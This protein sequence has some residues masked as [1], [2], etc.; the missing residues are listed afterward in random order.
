MSVIL[1]FAEQRNNTFRK[2]AFEVAGT[3]ARLAGDMGGQAVALVAGADVEGMGPELGKYGVSTVK[4]LSDASF[5]DYT[6]ESYATAV[7]EAAKTLDAKVILFPASSMGKDLAPRVAALLGC[8][9]ASDC[10]ELKVEDGNLSAKRPLYGG[11]VHAWVTA[12]TDSFVL[13]LRPNVFTA[14]AGSGGGGGGGWP[15]WTSS[16]APPPLPAARRP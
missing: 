16:T 12:T 1:A 11:K 3:A 15:R 14:E 6:G 10:I 9:M 8:G 2:T 5:K 13:T 7:C 4:A